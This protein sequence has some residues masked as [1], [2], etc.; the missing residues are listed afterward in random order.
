MGALVSQSPQCVLR[1]RHQR[2][3]LHLGPAH[4]R[5]SATEAGE[6]RRHKVSVTTAC[7]IVVTFIEMYFK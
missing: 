4:G 2:P 6:G 5:P 3:T 7:F 1:A